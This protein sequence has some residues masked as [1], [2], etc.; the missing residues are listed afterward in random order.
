MAKENY[1]AYLNSVDEKIGEILKLVIPVNDLSTASNL[2][3]KYTRDFNTALENIEELASSKSKSVDEV[4][5]EEFGHWVNNTMSS[6]EALGI[7]ASR[8]KPTRKLILNEMYGFGY[9]RLG[10]KKKS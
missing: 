2:I 10:I 1:T 9:D 8:W 6:C 3:V 5:T 4:I 7:Q